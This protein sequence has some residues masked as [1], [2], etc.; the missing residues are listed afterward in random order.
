[1]ASGIAARV[2]DWVEVRPLAEIMA[3]LNEYGALEAT[4]FMPEMAQ[5]A[6][7][8]FQILKSAHKTCDPTGASDLRLM[9]D[10]V[11][12][13]TRCDGAAHD[14]CEARCLLFWKT[15]WLKP[16][17]G[18]GARE[19]SPAPTDDVDLSRLHRATRRVTESGEL[20]HRCQVTEIV[21]ATTPL[22][23]SNLRQ[24]V[25]DVSSRNVLLVEFVRELVRAYA[26][27]IIRR[28]L[29]LIGIG[30]S[31]FAARR[32]DVATAAA[33]D[34]AK[35]DLQIGELVQIRPAEEILATLD[36]NRKNRGLVFEQEMLRHCGK[37][38]RVLARVSRI[39]DEKS[40]K[41]I[42]LTNGCIALEGLTCRG[43]DNR[44]RMFCPRGRSSTGARRGCSA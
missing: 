17:D 35:L 40:G 11:H 25:D 19:A 15:A 20:R 8:R 31:R 3:T 14:G 36:E 28:A 4:P 26:K 37:T 30:D 21:A 33:R 41:M 13:E 39:I 34:A 1:M 6:G 16:V 12:L 29:R 18:P 9:S 27:A 24:Y 7:R 42:K 44:Q 10:A 23:I 43:L 5:Y 2:G 32:P 22:P 38:Y